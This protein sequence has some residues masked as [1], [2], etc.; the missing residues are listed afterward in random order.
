[1]KSV[2]ARLSGGSVGTRICVALLTRWT[3][4][5]LLVLHLFSQDG[6]RAGHIQSPN[7]HTYVPCLIHVKD[8]VV[9]STQSTKAAP[10]LPALSFLSTTETPTTA[11]SSECFCRRPDS[12][13][14]WKWTGSRETERVQSPFLRSNRGFSHVTE[15]LQV[16]LQYI[17][18]T[19]SSNTNDTT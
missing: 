7:I 9:V 1:M 4:M 16:L 10:Q 17:Q 11:E 6:S 18:N 2:I 13:L 15:L 5:F 14:C 19:T 3:Q 8:E 12:G